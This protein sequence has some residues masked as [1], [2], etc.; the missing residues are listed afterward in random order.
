MLNNMLLQYVEVDDPSGICCAPAREWRVAVAARRVVPGD[1]PAAWRCRL[2]DRPIM[3][4]AL[5]HR[6]AVAVLRPCM[7]SGSWLWCSAGLDCDE[8]EAAR[9]RRCREPG[10]ACAVRNAHSSSHRSTDHMLIRPWSTVRVARTGG[11]RLRSGS[12]RIRR[13][14][15]S[16]RRRRHARTCR[17]HRCNEI[18]TTSLRI[19]YCPCRASQ[20]ARETSAVSR[21]Y[22]GYISAVYRLYLRRISVTSRLYLG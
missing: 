1:G 11:A 7:R 17:D 5:A 18:A 8:V 15:A 21:L 22:L 3:Y 4:P 14:R 2:A 19:V 10:G 16:R 12:V 20:S 9:G 13:A 6:M